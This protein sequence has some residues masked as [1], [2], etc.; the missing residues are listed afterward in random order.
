VTTSGPSTLFP[1]LR[2]RILLALAGGLASALAGTVPADAGQPSNVKVSVRQGGGGEEA[3]LLNGIEG[4]AALFALRPTEGAQFKNIAGVRPSPAS[5]AQQGYVAGMGRLQVADGT[6]LRVNYIG[7]EDANGATPG[8]AG[9]VRLSTRLDS[10]TLG[11]SETV[12]RGF[13]GPWTGYGAGAVANATDTWASWNIFSNLALGGGLRRGQRLGGEE[14][15]ELNL[16]QS[17]EIAGGWLSNS[18]TGSVG[19]L[20]GAA[21]GTLTYSR[22]LFDIAT[23][24]AGLDYQTGAG[25]QPS[26]AHMSA[27]SPLG[28]KWSLYADATKPLLDASP[29]RLDAGINGEVLGLTTDAYGGVA[30]DGAG[31]V[32]VR[33]RVPLSATPRRERWLAF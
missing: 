30:T 12:N 16:N 6:T 1:P 32:G 25:I 20:D 27:S 5:G 19:D 15:S 17:L 2:A 9:E 24:E 4:P 33:M 10:V 14:V 28:P 31:Y 3:G 23:L 22:M 29:A 7:D 18:L 11:L 26:M 21:G 8:G 13:E